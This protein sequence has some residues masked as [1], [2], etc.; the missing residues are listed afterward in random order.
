MKLFL[1][2]CLVSLPTLTP[3][4][5]TSKN[6]G[7]V[8]TRRTCVKTWRYTVLLQHHV[9]I[10]LP[11]KKSP[12]CLRKEFT[13]WFLSNTQIS[14]LTKFELKTARGW[15]EYNSDS[16]TSVI[17]GR[18]RDTHQIACN[19]PEILFDLPTPVTARF[20]RFIAKR[21]FVQNPQSPALG[22]TVQYFIVE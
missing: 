13:K 14:G 8:K 21:P 16:W 2:N 19:S 17:E 3:Q 5:E 18:I 10:L 12:C 20:F 15:G 9:Q 4:Y 11:N 22:P 1:T 6:S 7:G